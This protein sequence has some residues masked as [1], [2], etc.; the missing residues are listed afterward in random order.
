MKNVIKWLKNPASDFALFVIVLILANLVSAKAFLRFDLTQNKTYSLSAVSRQTV[1]T[2]E[3]PLSVKVFFSSNLPSPYNT[4]EQYVRDLLVEYKGAA[5]GKFSYE[6]YDM[7]NAENQ[8]IAQ[9]YNVRQVQIQEVKDNE[10]GFKQAWMGVVLLYADR[11]ETIDQITT[12][13]A[14]EYKLTTKMANMVATTNALSGLQGKIKMTLYAS[15]NLSVLGIDTAALEKIVRESYGTVNARNMNRIDFES[16]KPTGDEIDYLINTYGVQGLSFSTRSGEKYRGV[17]G[18]VLEGADSAK[19]VPIGVQ[20]SLFGYDVAGLDDLEQSIQDT[21]KSL[22]SKIQE[23][24]YVTGHGET[25]LNDS[26]AGAALFETLLSDMYSVTEVDLSKDAIPAGIKTLVIN[27]PKAEFSEAELYKIDQ[28]VMKGG[29][30][31]LFIDP[32]LEVQDGTQ[33]SYFYNQPAYEPI[34]TGLSTLLDKYGAKIEKGYVY[35]KKCYSTVQQGMGKLDLNWVPMLQ[36][37]ELNQKNPISANLGFVLFVQTGAVDISNAADGVK[38]TVLAHSSEQSWLKSDGIILN[39]NMIAA[40]KAEEMKPYNLAVMLEGSFESAFDAPV[41]QSSTEDEQ[42]EG[43][44]NTIALTSE[45]HIKKSAQKGKIFVAATSTITSAQLIDEAGTQ[46]IA[47]FVRNVIDSL[48]GN[49]DLCS[50]RTKGLSSLNTLN[51]RNGAAVALAKL[52]N[53]YVLVIILALLGLIAW[54]KR[55]AHKKAIRA[56]FDPNDSRE[57]DTSRESNAQKASAQGAQ[58][59]K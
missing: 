31:A 46:P 47:I 11:I 50:M 56:R 36:R 4:V 18:L 27:G 24:G 14:L 10:V 28:F 57:G 15:D 8:E 35:D 19:A 32:F 26:Q 42:T 16:V 23:I 13:D 7:D 52:F 59:G 1:R 25:D 43:A 58:E 45:T 37:G 22:V 9:K 33:Q 21:L 20:R 34:E 41:A 12:S 49:A 6:F 30:L 39:P 5:N 51:A 17:L 38:A 2:L 29:N 54:S 40:P 3:E 55:S 48:N 44:E 53:Q